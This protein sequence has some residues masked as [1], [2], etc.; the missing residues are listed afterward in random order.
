M[1]RLVRPC[2]RRPWRGGGNR[3][4]SQE[5]VLAQFRWEPG[6]SP[7]ASGQNDNGT[8]VGLMGLAA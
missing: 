6:Q 1:Q 7:S 5:D 4:G 2:H 8:A 3:Q